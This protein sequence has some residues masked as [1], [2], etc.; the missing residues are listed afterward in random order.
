[1]VDRPGEPH[2]SST[3]HRHYLGVLDIRLAATRSRQLLAGGTCHGS[4]RRSPGQPVPRYAPQGA[5]GY[6]SLSA[7]IRPEVVPNAARPLALT[8]SRVDRFTQ[9]ELQSPRRSRLKPL[10]RDLGLCS[11]W[12]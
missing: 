4:T 1:M 10:W 8:E 5:T 2:G 6:A 11:A 12:R 9:G 7:H 3:R